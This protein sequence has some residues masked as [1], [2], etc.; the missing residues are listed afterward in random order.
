MVEALKQMRTYR[1]DYIVNPSDEKMGNILSFIIMNVERPM[2]KHCYGPKFDKVIL[3]QFVSTANRIR[4]SICTYKDFL[5]YM[6]ILIEL[7][8]SINKNDEKKA[9]GWMIV[10]DE[11][12]LKLVYYDCIP[13][14][15]GSTE[16]CSFHNK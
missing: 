8:D 12:L 15:D 7:V 10:S 4:C 3:K 1:N 16:P 11:N 6:S 2:L 13:H 14:I 9:Y 5:D